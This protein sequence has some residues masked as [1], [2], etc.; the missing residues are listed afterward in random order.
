MGV[1]KFFVLFF[2]LL[3][4]SLNSDQLQS[5]AFSTV[6]NLMAIVEVALFQRKFEER[7]C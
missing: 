7:G 2:C 1:N 6:R 3:L 5:R 4:S